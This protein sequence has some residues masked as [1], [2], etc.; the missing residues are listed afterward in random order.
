MNTININDFTKFPGLRYCS[1]SEKSGE[2][3]Y[4]SVLNKA[5]ADALK[6]NTSLVVNLDCTDGYA[7]SFLDEAFGNLVYDFTLNEVKNR[8]KIISN[9]EPHW[10]KM[11]EEQSFVE[12]EKRREENKA[13]SVTKEHESWF[14]LRDGRLEEGVWLTPSPEE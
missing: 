5:F 8:V 9:E 10:K 11:I 12:W 2:E 7:S 3:Y 4:H 6:N 13:P 14:R 1:I